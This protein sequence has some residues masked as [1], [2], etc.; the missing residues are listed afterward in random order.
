[1]AVVI[2]VLHDAAEREDRGSAAMRVGDFLDPIVTAAPES[3]LTEVLH[4]LNQGRPVAVSS[5]GRWQLV[6]PPA[7]GNRPTTGLS[8]LPR[9]AVPVIAPDRRISEAFVAMLQHDAPYIL[10]VE[11]ERLLGVVGRQRLVDQVDAGDCSPAKMALSENESHL[12]LLVEQMPAVLFT[13]DLDLR[14][15]SSTGAGLAGLGLRPNQVNGL[16]VYEYFQTTDPEFLP[17]AAAR[18]AVAG[19]SVTFEITW[20][21]RTFHSHV[22]PFLDPK[23]NTIGCIGIGFDITERKHIE[24]ALRESEELHRVISELTSDYAYVCEVDADGTIRMVSATEGFVRFSGY[25]VAEVE[26]RGGWPIL[27]HPDDLPGLLALQPSMLATARGVNEVRLVTKS[28]ETRWIRYSTQPIW[29]AAQGRVVRLLGAVQDITERKQAEEN[30]REYAEQLQSLSRRLL[31]MQE[32]ERRHLA[33]EL[34]DQIG[35]ALTGLKLSL[36]MVPRLPPAKAAATLK[37]ADLLINDLITQVR[38][39]SLDLRPGMLDDFGLLPALLW[40]FK[41][42]TD[43]TSVQVNFEHRELE[44][45]F[46]PDVETAAY[47]LVQE[48]LTNVARHAGVAQVTVRIWLD[49]DWLNVQVD[50]MGVG[51]EQGLMPKARLSGGLTGMRER[52]YILGGRLHVESTPGAGTRLSAEFPAA[53][54]EPRRQQHGLDAHVG[55]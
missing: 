6:L 37:D 41:R 18:R 25:T 51:F 42:Y 16:S 8:E 44:R 12:R 17:V 1:M 3:A 28:G 15:T 39:L 40:H 55:R 24:Q 2:A 27:I 48:A 52:A 20:Q 11:G 34:H 13:T 53:G 31:H 26:A 54:P 22:E 23:G 9:V 29:D 4:E 7:A 38:N 14:F 19:E 21:G 35:Q 5:A 33:R 43:Q 32:D 47:R 49:G 36:E 30:R 10:V 50:D 46:H 45:R